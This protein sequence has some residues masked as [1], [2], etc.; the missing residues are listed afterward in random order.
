MRRTSPNDDSVISVTGR[1]SSKR[2]RAARVAEGIAT[3][4][5]G[6]ALAW[7]VL[8]P[9]DGFVKVLPPAGAC[10]AGLNG[11]VSGVGGIYSWRR[12]RGWGCF[13]LDSTWGLVGVSLGVLL[14]AVNRFHSDPGYH[15]GMSR[16]SNR[17]VYEGGFSV[18]AGFALA[19]G[20][21]V[22][23]GGGAVGLRGDSQAAARRRRLVDV[24]EGTHLL[25]NRALGPIFSIVYPC[26]MVLAGAVGMMVGLVTDRRHVWMVMETFAYYNNPFEYWAYRKDS[27]WPPHGAYRRYAWRSR[28]TSY[29]T[30]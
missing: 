16:R 7:V 24:H 25:Q 1:A 30:S 9:L 2:A 12:V 4:I 21:V 20:N 27:Y 13:L 29:E 14:H 18:R 19:M 15:M 23:A 10:M 3:G 8:A 26:W 5:G 22:S 17:H 6:A 11:L 28:R